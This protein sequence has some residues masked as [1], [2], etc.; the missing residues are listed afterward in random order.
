MIGDNAT[1]GMG[2]TVVKNVKENT[3]VF[4]TAAKEKV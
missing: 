4:G 3:V 1:I 2:S